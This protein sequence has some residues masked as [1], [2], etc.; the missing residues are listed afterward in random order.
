V[1]LVFDA[2][3]RELFPE[4][5]APVRGYW[6]LVVR[7]RDDRVERRKGEACREIQSAFSLEGLKDVEVFRIY[8]NFLWRLE[9][10]P[11]KVR[12]S[13]EALVR[14]ALQGKEFPRVN[15]LVDCCNIA[16]A[17]SGVPIAA[18]DADKLRGRLRLRFAA[19]GEPFLGIG[20][21]GS[22]SLSGKELVIEDELGPVA[23][24][25]YRDSERTKITLETRA[26]VAVL[27][28]VPGVSRSC[29]E[30]AS[31]LLDELISEFAKG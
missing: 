24:Y 2:R 23:V 14:R 16:S 3:V 25:L 12:P 10:D 21:G 18:F 5:E 22:L 8:R 1:E 11:T 27:C 26:C 15:T 20:M 29:L 9:I 19:R 13:S 7:D 4:L 30:R 17:L 31:S 28:G 6:G